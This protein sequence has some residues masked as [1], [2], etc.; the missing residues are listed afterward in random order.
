MPAKRLTTRCKYASRF[1]RSNSRDPAANNDRAVFDR[2]SF[3]DLN[4]IQTN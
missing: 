1:G 2:D 4:N 3:K